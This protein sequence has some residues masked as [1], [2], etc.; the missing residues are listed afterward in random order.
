MAVA[1]R[2]R[3]G[4]LSPRGLRLLGYG[5]AACGFLLLGVVL[6]ERGILGDGTGAGGGD[7]LA[8]HAAAQRLLSG[9]PLYVE[10]P[11]TL[12]AFLYPPAFA[13]L[14][15]P[16]GLLSPAAFVWLW[17]AIGLAG[18]RVAMGSWTAAGI[19]TLVY[20]PVIFELEVANLN[21]VLAGICAMVMRGQAGLV[22]AAFVTKF[23]ALP[24]VPLGFVAD[25]RGLLAGGVVAGAAIVVSLLTVPQLWSDYVQ[26][27]RSSVEPTYWANLL[28]GVPIVL[29]LAV[30]MALGVA[31]ARYRRLAPLAM[32]VGLPVVWLSSLSIL[33]AT[34]A[35]MP[36]ATLGGRV[37]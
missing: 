2:L 28:Y 3:P 14:I 33:V 8:Y 30:A 13:Q 26:F 9:A 32:L 21:L 29:R 34:A 23:A 24:L 20:P 22:G 31:A 15:A 4:R 10:R 16:L 6:V 17:R 18:L 36:R 27:L 37:S 11:G 5:L 12:L 7:A 19:A 1:A 35:P 25:R